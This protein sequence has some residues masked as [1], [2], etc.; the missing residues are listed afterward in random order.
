MQTDLH[1]FGFS[2]VAFFSTIELV[3]SFSIRESTA[4]KTASAPIGEMVIYSPS[5]GC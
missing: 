3:A 1:I 5:K 4:S 2:N